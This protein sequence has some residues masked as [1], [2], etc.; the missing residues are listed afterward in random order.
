MPAPVLCPHCRKK[1]RIDKT[2]V[3]RRLKCRNC[4]EFFQFHAI[5]EPSD[6][7]DAPPA[8]RKRG[9]GGLPGWVVILV[10]VGVPAAAWYGFSLLGGSGGR[11]QDRLF[12]ALAEE[13]D[14][15]IELVR[16]ADSV[17][18]AE[19]AQL[20]ITGH[21]G[22]VNRLLSDPR[23]F[24]RSRAVVGAALLRDHGGGMQG[25]LD[26]LRDAKKEKFALQGVGRYISGSMGQ[27]PQT[28]MALEERLKE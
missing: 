17:E 18:A 7:E 21:V 24:G 11:P 16:G 26:R 2:D 19:E 13:Y 25:R 27:L 3:D 1:Y 4:G 6:I 5:E 28:R 9:P 14:A 22:E 10:L 12:D 8:P 20:R 23:P 15:I